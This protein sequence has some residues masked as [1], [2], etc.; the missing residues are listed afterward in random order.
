MLYICISIPSLQIGSSIPFFQILH[1]CINTLYLFF[2][3]WLI[4]LCITSSRFIHLTR[5]DSNLCFYGWVIFH[6]IYSIY[7][8]IYLYISIYIYIYLYISIYIYIYIDIHIFFIHL[9]VDGHLDCFQV[10]A[11]VN[12]AAMN[13]EV[14]VSF[15]VMVFSR[16][17]PSSGIAGPYGSFITSF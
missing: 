10:L 12:G 9:S 6:Y 15:S 14:H 8:Y 13:P 17:M 4:S 2:S 5:T 3:F 16:Y 7:I 11:I 1:T